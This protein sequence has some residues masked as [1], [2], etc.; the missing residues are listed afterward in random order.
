MEGWDLGDKGVC[1][2]KARTQKRQSQSWRDSQSQ[3]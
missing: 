1:G 2:G 3:P